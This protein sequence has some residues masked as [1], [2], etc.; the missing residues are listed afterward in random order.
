MAILFA[1]LPLRPSLKLGLD[2]IVCKTFAMPVELVGATM[3]VGVGGEFSAIDTTVTV[4]VMKTF[5]HL[6]FPLPSQGRE[7]PLPPLTMT[8]SART[9]MQQWKNR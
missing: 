8:R 3:I 2:V 9:G 1:R 4:V 5:S 6:S 7:H